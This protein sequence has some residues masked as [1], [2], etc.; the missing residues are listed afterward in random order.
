M[1]VSSR[2]HSHLPS[3]GR[4][5]QNQ[6]SSPSH[7][8]ANRN[9]YN[10]LPYT[11]SSP[12]PSEA[13]LEHHEYLDESN[14]SSATAPVVLDTS[15]I[16]I[17]NIDLFMPSSFDF[18]SNQA[19]G[20]SIPDATDSIAA[21]WHLS[22]GNLGRVANHMGVI[23]RGSHDHQ[24][25]PSTSSIGSVA[26]MSA[27]PGQGLQQASRGVRVN[28]QRKLT[29]GQY[30]DNQS[31]RSHL[32]SPRQTPTR[33]TFLT[34]SSQ[35]YT[36][37][38]DIN[39]TVAASLAMNSALLAPSHQQNED[40]M[41]QMSRSN[42]PSFSSM[43]QGPATPATAVSEHHDQSQRSVQNDMSSGM[44]PKFERTYTDA[45]Q[46][47]LYFGQDVMASQAA[48]N[49]NF[50]MPHGNKMVNERLLEAQMA[51]SQSSGST[52]SI[53]MSPFRAGYMPN[54][55]EPSDLKYQ[56]SP[57]TESEP[58][59]ISPKD[60]VLDYKPSS[61]DFPL[62]PQSTSGMSGSYA[63][64]APTPQRQYAQQNAVDFSSVTSAPS[65]GT[66][67]TLTSAPLQ[68][69]QG[70]ATPSLPTNMGLSNMATGY[71][72]NPLSQSARTVSRQT[73]RT[74]EFPAQ[75]TSMESS[76]SEAAPPS[77]QA[78]SSMMLN[79][80][81]PDSAADTGTYSCTYHGCLRRFSTP[82]KLQRHKRDEHRNNP[83]VTPGVGS[84]M[85]TAELMER[86]SQT[87]P[88]KCD[89]I[90][91][92]TGKSCNTVFSRPYDLTRHEDTIH[93]VRKQK[94]RCAICTEEKTFSRSD[95]LTR[96][97]RVVHPEIDFPGKHRKRGSRGD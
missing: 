7:L 27:T 17:S 44:V 75:L 53:P 89:R 87:G 74:P 63:A 45:L 11:S 5:T 30:R 22:G 92:T 72:G 26:S 20:Y 73:D 61:N 39:S 16:P 34:S 93:N 41:S 18:Q 21:M 54:E 37:N 31:A 65:W 68:S 24:R 33:S 2:D 3:P 64:V 4:A 80:P 85:S 14:K 43:G 94:V 52:Q 67:M 38:Q 96:H 95:A 25:A 66:G 50:L 62:F 78:S 82:Q 40:E 79:S 76:A 28:D 59:T 48:S 15:N 23:P 46:D 1:L 90:N 70:F 69:Y 6:L 19:N 56:M 32:P 58:K 42:R 8:A 55:N 77:S 83:N 91:P 10:N 9:F 84:G 97:M 88:H 51:R 36:Q 71:L 13:S 35:A 57:N 81:K 47:E 29:P 60:A 86:N 49:P 12:S